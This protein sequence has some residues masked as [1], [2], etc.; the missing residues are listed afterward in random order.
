MSV[1]E[2]LSFV[3]SD[4][5]SPSHLELSDAH[6]ETLWDAL[7]NNNEQTEQQPHADLLFGWLSYYADKHQLTNTTATTT[8]TT[9]SSEPDRHR[10]QQLQ[11][12]Q[13]L[14]R[15]HVMST[16]ALSSLF[17][18]RMC[19]LPLGRFTRLAM[20]LYQQLYTIYITEESSSSSLSSK[21]SIFYALRNRC[22]C[23]CECSDTCFNK[24]TL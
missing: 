15:F 24:K 5:G 10:L 6:I 23:C 7:I 14:Q 19:R 11:Q 13:Q 22:C 4:T 3:F 8:A 9:T 16:R 21:K 18:S 12:Q 17:V 1:L 2:W 20:R